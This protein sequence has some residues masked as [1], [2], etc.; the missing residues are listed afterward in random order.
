MDTSPVW[1]ISGPVFLVAFAPT[2][3]LLAVFA[4]AVRERAV[5]RLPETDDLHG[6]VLACLSPRRSWKDDVVVASLVRL[7]SKGLVEVA[8]GRVVRPVGG[9]GADLADPLGRAVCRAVGESEEI[10]SLKG[11]PAVASELLR[12]Q[13]EY[14]EWEAGA[15]RAS[16]AAARRARPALLPL[17]A[18]L[19]V[20]SV[21]FLADVVNGEPTGFLLLFVSFLL[22]LGAA[23]PLLLRRWVPTTPS[24]DWSGELRERREAM[25]GRRLREARSRP[26][27]H[28]ADQNVDELVLSTAY[29]GPTLLRDEVPE[30]AALTEAER[31]AALGE[32]AEKATVQKKKG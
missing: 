8:H 30:L 5:S 13:K 32:E 1:G 11:H 3:V 10:R 25:A 14:R 4:L 26:L 16:Q 2:G 21:R 6:Y 20:G 28:G 19:A 17:G 15:R 24:R 23:I 9:G 18:L 29:F 31:S 7:R 12:L 22:L 27:P